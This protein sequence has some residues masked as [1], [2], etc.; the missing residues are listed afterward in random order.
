MS[1]NATALKIGD[2]VATHDGD[3]GIIT[4]KMEG[5]LRVALP[6]KRRIR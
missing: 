3:I 5:Y 2:R 1:D 4:G 6:D